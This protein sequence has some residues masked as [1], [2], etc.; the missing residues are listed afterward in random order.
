[1]EPN[2]KLHPFQLHRVFSTVWPDVEQLIGKGRKIDVVG[3]DSCL[4]ST[5]EIGYELRNYVDY[6]VSSQGSVDDIGWPYRELLSW[7]KENS[8]ATPEDLIKQTVDVYTSYFVDYAIIAKS[9]SSLAAL[10]LSAF[11]DL[12]PAIKTFVSCSQRGPCSIPAAGSSCSTTYH[13]L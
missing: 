7:L 8:T 3:L 12:A 11:A 9:S 4:M 1:M 6:L 5:A 10:K 13:R 2:K